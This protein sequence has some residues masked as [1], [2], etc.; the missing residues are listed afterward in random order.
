MF[1][2]DPFLWLYI[3][4][5]FWKCGLQ[6]FRSVWAS[7]RGPA[8]TKLFSS[9]QDIICL[10][11]SVVIHTESWVNHCYFSANHDSDTKLLILLILSPY[12]LLL[13][14]N[15]WWQPPGRAPV[16]L[17]IVNYI[18]S[19]FPW[20]TIF[21]EKNDWWKT[22]NGYSDLD[23]WWMFSQNWMKP[24]YHFKENWWLFVASDKAWDFWQIP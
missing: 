19:F 10:S 24:S 14:T 1:S 5:G 23:V 13:C 9:S 2:A 6:T 22:M 21:T 12:T 4:Q 8:K 15:V 11:S 7:F 18:S 20:N 16:W 17:W 3:V